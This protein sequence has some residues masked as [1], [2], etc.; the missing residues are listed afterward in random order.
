[1]KRI[2]YLFLL[3]GG[4]TLFA[5][6][7]KDTTV[8]KSTEPLVQK[9]TTIDDTESAVEADDT[10]S[11][12]DEYDSEANTYEASDD[13]AA[14]EETAVSISDDYEVPVFDEE[15]VALFKGRFKS[16]YESLLAFKDDPNFHQTGFAQPGKFHDWIVEAQNLQD[17]PISDQ[18][19]NQGLI[20]NELVILG[21]QYLETK[22]GENN[23][24]LM[25]NEDFK[26]I[27]Y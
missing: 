10:Y 13:Y 8:K 14:T 9:A 5:C 23:T 1:M 21:I 25:F 11:S 7:G 2:S 26:R 18:L 19:M 17:N 22:G 6:G 3:A 20:A 4:L 24:T 27:L 15:E 12:T 16:T